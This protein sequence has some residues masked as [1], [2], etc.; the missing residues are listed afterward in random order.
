MSSENQKPQNPLSNHP[1]FASRIAASI[2][3][4]YADSLDIDGLCVAA[5]GL[6]K[7]L[8]PSITPGVDEVGN[9]ALTETLELPDLGGNRI[10][11][12]RER[13]ADPFDQTRVDVSNPDTY[14]LPLQIEIYDAVGEV[15]RDIFI[16]DSRL[17]S[18]G[19]IV[20]AKAVDARS[21]G[22]IHDMQLPK[23]DAELF[24]RQ[25]RSLTRQIYARNR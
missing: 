5:D 8:R 16:Q 17:D 13:Q 25:M 22:T 2:T 1:D 7:L 21:A 4:T 15:S 11:M 3:E 10:R 24:I 18:S 20:E 23:R 19:N 12:S 9:Y 14:T 6:F